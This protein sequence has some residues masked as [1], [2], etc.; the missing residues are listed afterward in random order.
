MNAKIL[1]LS[2]L[3][4]LSRLQFQEQ[5]KAAANRKRAEQFAQLH[6]I[7]STI[8]YMKRSVSFPPAPIAID[9]PLKIKTKVPAGVPKLAIHSNENALDVA[10]RLQTQVDSN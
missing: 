8:G 9:G 3:I 5:A 2:F 7:L 10:F 4:N 1:I 6:P